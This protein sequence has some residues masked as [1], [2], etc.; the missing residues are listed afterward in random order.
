[1]DA[2]VTEPLV[3]GGPLT[4]SPAIELGGMSRQEIIEQR[5]GLGL[6]PE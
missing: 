6:K 5:H 2:G 4:S 3:R 1:M